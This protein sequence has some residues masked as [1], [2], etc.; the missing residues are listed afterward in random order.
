[1]PHAPTFAMT[2]SAGDTEINRVLGVLNQFGNALR[3]PDEA[4]ARLAGALRYSAHTDDGIDAL[5]A[6]EAA[7]ESRA[8]VLLTSDPQDL[9]RLLASTPQVSVRRV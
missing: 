9:N 1:M 5:V 2:R 8:T 3:A 6:A 4:T 7:R